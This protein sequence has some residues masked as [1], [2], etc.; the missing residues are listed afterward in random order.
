MPANIILSTVDRYCYFK[1]LIAVCYCKIKC[2]VNFYVRLVVD[3][4]YELRFDVSMISLDLLVVFL[5]VL[6]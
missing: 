1:V 4:N 2:P 5:W 3:F 6:G